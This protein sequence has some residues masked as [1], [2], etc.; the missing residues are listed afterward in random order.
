MNHVTNMMYKNR[1]E[2]DKSNKVLLTS[3][4][5]GARSSSWF[6]EQEHMAATTQS[7]TLELTHSVL[8]TPIK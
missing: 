3:R 8:Q 5:L 6:L 1:T 4:V 2:T 7:N